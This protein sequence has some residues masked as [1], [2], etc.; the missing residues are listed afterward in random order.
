MA[1]SLSKILTWGINV[2][3]GFKPFPTGKTY[4][5]SEII[6]RFK[7]FSSKDINLKFGK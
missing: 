5:L 6:R 3:N 2:G 4:G 7:I 1:L